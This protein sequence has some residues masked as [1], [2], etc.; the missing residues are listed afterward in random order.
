MYVALSNN[1]IIPLLTKPTLTSA[2]YATCAAG[3]ALFKIS[4]STS[5]NASAGK[6]YLLVS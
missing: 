4:P 6:K 5:I 3:L 2:A 1:A